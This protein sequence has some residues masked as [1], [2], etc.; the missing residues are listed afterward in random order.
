MAAVYVFAFFASLLFLAAFVEWQYRRLVRRREVRGR[1]LR[2]EASRAELSALP[3]LWNQR[4]GPL[5]PYNY[6]RDGV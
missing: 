6:E 2:I 5:R 1:L 4:R 3:S